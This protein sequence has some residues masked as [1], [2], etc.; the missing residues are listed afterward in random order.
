MCTSDVAV[1]DATSN[2]FQWQGRSIGLDQAIPIYAYLMTDL[3]IP[4]EQ[5]AVVVCT[6]WLH[7]T[8]IQAFPDH[9]HSY[10]LE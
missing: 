7:N 6:L 9:F 4:A 10:L 2:D 8:C 1:A 5:V 3:R